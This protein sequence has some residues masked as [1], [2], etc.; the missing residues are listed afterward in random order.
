MSCM[1]DMSKVLCDILVVIVL[2]TYIILE[3]K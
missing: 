2:L 1:S 3:E